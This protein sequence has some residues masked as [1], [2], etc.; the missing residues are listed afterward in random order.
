MLKR[1]ILLILLIIKV[2]TMEEYI[3]DPSDRKVNEIIQTLL[4]DYENYMD[5]VDSLVFLKY[6]E[7]K[8]KKL[9]SK[10][11]IQFIVN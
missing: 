3:E 11:Y 4:N 1:K 7:E 5:E 6:P 2:T 10:R 8:A 9:I